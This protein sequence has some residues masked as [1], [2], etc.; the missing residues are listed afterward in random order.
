M[1]NSKS[2]NIINLGNKSFK[3]DLYQSWFNIK[4]ITNNNQLTQVCNNICQQ[5]KHEKKWILMINPEEQTLEQL[6]HL[7]DLDTSKILRV[8]M[9]NTELNLTS[10]KN[11]LTKGN[12]SAV[13]LADTKLNQDEIA[14]LSDSAQQGQTQCIVLKNTITLH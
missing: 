5:H 8:N 14:Q 9:K 13:I 1:F 12:C 4:D 6:N 11:V 3:R 10:I 2:C 7:Q